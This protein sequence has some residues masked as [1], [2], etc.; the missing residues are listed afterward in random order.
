MDEV[1]SRMSARVSALPIVLALLVCAP[2]AHAQGD[3]GAS[4]QE[5]APVRANE[6]K[7][8][9]GAEEVRIVRP[10]GWV[11]GEAP[12]GSLA[13]MRASGDASSQLEVRY[14][15]EITAA[16]QKQ[17][18]SSFHTSL[19]QMG[20]EEVAE[21]KK[22]HDGAFPAGVETEYRL[23]SA[24]KP[25]R[26]I[27]WHVHREKGAWFFTLF[28]PEEARDTHYE[29]LTELIVGVSFAKKK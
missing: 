19:K 11:V 29:A 3:D 8:L 5:G 28:C 17:H 16:K 25:F 27:V 14:T 7:K 23:V 18:F 4:G 21:A 26:L 13:L 22:K 20:L 12:K 10:D 15:P 24:G 6:V 9:L 1:I 2:L